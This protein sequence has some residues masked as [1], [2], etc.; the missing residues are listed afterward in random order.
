MLILLFV[1]SFS[2]FGQ[3][4]PA[5][6]AIPSAQINEGDEIIRVNTL[7]PN[8]PVIASNRESCNIAEVKKEDLSVYQGSEKQ[9]IEFFAVSE[10]PM[11]VAILIDASFNTRDV[12]DDI[13]KRRGNSLHCLIPKTR[14]LL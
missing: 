5:T 8:I 14:E 9:N 7:L 11:N 2:A 4:S 1:V 12:L 3:K 13:K 10:A 6:S